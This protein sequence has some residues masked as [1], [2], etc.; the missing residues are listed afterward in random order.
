MSLDSRLHPIPVA[1]ASSA[2]AAFI[3]I[4]HALRLC[5]CPHKSHHRL[6]YRLWEVVPCLGEFGDFRRDWGSRI[7]VDLFR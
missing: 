3:S 1:P 2:G 7:G 6:T 5:G 4:D